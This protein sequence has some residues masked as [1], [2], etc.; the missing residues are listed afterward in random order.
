MAQQFTLSEAAR[1]LGISL[2]RV[3]IFATAKGLGNHRGNV[4]TFSEADVKVMRTLSPARASI[5]RP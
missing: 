2:S 4:W 5:P 3:H 1:E